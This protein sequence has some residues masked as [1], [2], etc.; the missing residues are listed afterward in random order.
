MTLYSICMGL[1]MP[2]TDPEGGGDRLWHKWLQKGIKQLNGY[3][4]NE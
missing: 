1:I 3:E 4:V 2:P